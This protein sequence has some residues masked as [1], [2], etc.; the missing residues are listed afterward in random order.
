MLSTYMVDL[1]QECLELHSI[2]PLEVFRLSKVGSQS[3]CV[4]QRQARQEESTILTS[5]V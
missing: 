3:Y 1:S 4:Q 5:G 2:W